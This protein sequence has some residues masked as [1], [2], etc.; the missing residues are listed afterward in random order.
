[1]HLARCLDPVIEGEREPLTEGTRQPKSE[2]CLFLL[3]TAK[4]PVLPKVRIDLVLDD[5]PSQWMG[6]R[7]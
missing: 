1:M 3:L 2:E 6:L 5:F 7:F 4:F